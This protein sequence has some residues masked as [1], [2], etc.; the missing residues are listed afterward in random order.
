M[1]TTHLYLSG[2][3]PVQYEMSDFYHHYDIGTRQNVTVQLAPES[4]ICSV[5]YQFFFNSCTHLC[6]AV[7]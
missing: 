5:V 4:F 7:G 2:Q 3:Q 6:T 1:Q